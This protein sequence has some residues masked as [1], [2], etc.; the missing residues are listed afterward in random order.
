MLAL[1]ADVV[2]ADIVTAEDI[3]GSADEIS[4]GSGCCQK[5]KC[6]SSSQ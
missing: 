1:T 6:Q 3:I 5:S 2:T 4:A